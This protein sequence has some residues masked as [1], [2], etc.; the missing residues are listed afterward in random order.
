MIDQ[1]IAK[2]RQ[3]RKAIHPSVQKQLPLDSRFQDAQDQID[4]LYKRYRHVISSPTLEAITDVSKI[5]SEAALMHQEREAFSIHRLQ[6]L[7]KY[8]KR[9][10]TGQRVKPAGDF[11][12]SVGF[13]DIQAQHQASLAAAEVKEQRSQPLFSRSVI[14]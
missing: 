4:H 5:I 6:R 9:R 7:E 14:I 13:H 1:I 10:K 11:I 12:T 8:G 2:Q 3:Q